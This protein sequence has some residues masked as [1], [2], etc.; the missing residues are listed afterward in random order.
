MRRHSIMGNNNDTRTSLRTFHPSQGGSN[1]IESNRYGMFNSS[2]Y[3]AVAHT[4]STSARRVGVPT[5]KA[6]RREETI[7]NGALDMP[8]DQSDT[9]WRCSRCRL[10]VR[11]GTAGN[12]TVIIICKTRFRNLWHYAFI[13]VRLASSTKHP[14]H[15][16]IGA[17]AVRTEVWI[18]Y[19][20]SFVRSFVAGQS[21]A[22]SSYK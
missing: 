21:A 13:R 12:T 10:S 8:V 11:H 1:R 5:P 2:L 15:K 14:Q 19:I 20:H 4:Q 7:G 16:H 3:R 22:K 17:T 6:K 18:G 9:G